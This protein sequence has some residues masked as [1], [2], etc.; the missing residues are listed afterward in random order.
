MA[1]IV[2][3]FETKS[4]G[5]VKPPNGVIVGSSYYVLVKVSP[6][7]RNC[8]TYKRVTFGEFIRRGRR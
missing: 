6:N 3:C 7:I 2:L 1:K 4:R 5:V 8:G